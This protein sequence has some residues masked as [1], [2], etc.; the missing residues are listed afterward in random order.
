MGRA[1]LKRSERTSFYLILMICM[2]LNVKCDEE[3][4]NNSRI[5]VCDDGVVR[6]HVSLFPQCL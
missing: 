5:L 3:K 4:A 2:S 1:S 6:R